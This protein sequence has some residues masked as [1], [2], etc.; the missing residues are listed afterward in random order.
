MTEEFEDVAV[1]AED[2]DNARDLTS[3]LVITTTL[4][5]LGALVV[6]LYAMNTYFA[7][8]PFAK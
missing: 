3:G 6:M 4:T 7:I 2:L 8:G 1:E 5:L